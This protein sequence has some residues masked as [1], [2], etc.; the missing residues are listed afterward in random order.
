MIHAAAAAAAARSSDRPCRLSSGCRGLIYWQRAIVVETKLQR[1]GYFLRYHTERPMTLERKKEVQDMIEKQ[2]AQIP[3]DIA[4]D[5]SNWMTRTAVVCALSSSVGFLCWWS[6]H[7][8]VDWWHYKNKRYEPNLTNHN[9]QLY[10]INHNFPPDEIIPNLL[11]GA[12]SWGLFG[13]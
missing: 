1:N 9:F 6:I 8:C 7:Y 3:R 12:I 13:I 11:L 5:F 2:V 10:D 4:L